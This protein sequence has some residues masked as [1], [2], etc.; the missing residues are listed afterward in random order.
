MFFSLRDVR[1]SWNS[2]LGHGFIVKPVTLFDF[3]NKMT[4]FTHFF[5]LGELQ[6]QRRQMAQS[7]PKGL[8]FFST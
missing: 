3:K 8:L 1:L 6:C 4:G 5:S 7:S 2:P